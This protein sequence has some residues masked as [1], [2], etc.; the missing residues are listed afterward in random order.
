[1]SK[2]HKVLHRLW[3]KAVDTPG[4]VK[5]DWIDLQQF[6]DKHDSVLQIEI[7]D[8]SKGSARVMACYQPNDTHVSVLKDQGPST[9][10]DV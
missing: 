4:Y 10:T 3:G 5:S 7:T 1:M 2:I 6:V 8:R 9:N